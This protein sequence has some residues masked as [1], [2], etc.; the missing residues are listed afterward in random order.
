MFRYFMM[1]TSAL[2]MLSQIQAEEPTPIRILFLGDQGHH[3]PIERFRQLQPVMAKR[4]IDL[5]YTEDVKF[6]NPKL[7]AKYDGLMIYANIDKISPEQEKS[8]D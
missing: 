2:L 5:T 8:T 1:F 4:G 6:L 3:V 7:L